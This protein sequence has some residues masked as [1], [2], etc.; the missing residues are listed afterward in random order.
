MFCYDT[1]YFSVLTS[2]PYV[3]IMSVCYAVPS[4]K[5]FA[6]FSLNS[7]QFFTKNDRTNVN[8]VKIGSVKAIF[9][10]RTLVNLQSYLHVYCP[11]W[12]KS[13]TRNLTQLHTPSDAISRYVIQTNEIFVVI[14][15]Q[16]NKC[17]HIERSFYICICLR[18]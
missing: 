11:I 15:T 2:I 3:E 9:Y 6:G 13:G 8:F 1:R 14:I 12:V 7:V 10:I 18:L 5:T 4:T 17:L 16:A